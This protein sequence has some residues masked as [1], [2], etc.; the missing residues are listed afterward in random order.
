[1]K[2][3]TNIEVSTMLTPTLT[4]D[5]ID[6]INRKIS[7]LSDVIS[8]IKIKNP[9][10]F[11]NDLNWLI[12]KLDS[13]KDNPAYERNLGFEEISTYI[14]THFDHNVELQDTLKEAVHN[15]KQDIYLS[16]P[17]E[18][19]SLFVDNYDIFKETKEKAKQT[20]DTAS[21]IKKDPH[22]AVTEILKD[23]QSQAKLYEGAQPEGQESRAARDTFLAY[24]EKRMNSIPQQNKRPKKTTSIEDLLDAEGLALY[25]NAIAEE[26]KSRAFR[27]AVFLKSTQHYDGPKW[28]KKL[29]LWVGGPSAS[30]KTYA[31]SEAVKAMATKM[32]HATNEE[33]E[34]I[35]TGNDV[36]SVDGGIE[37]EVSQMR[38]LVLQVALSKGYKGISDL[39]AN[40]KFDTKERV[41]AAALAQEDLS[42]VIPETFAESAISLKRFDKEGAYKKNEMREYHEMPNVVQ[43][44]SEVKAAPGKEKSFQVAVSH[45]GSSRAWF[46]EQ[47][48]FEE[49]DIKINNREIGCE[50]KVYDWK[51]FY[52]GKYAS[53]EACNNLKE[54]NPEGT[55]IQITNDLIFVKSNP[56]GTWQ[57][58]DYNDT[59]DLKLSSRDFERWQLEKQQSPATKGLVEWYAD[60]KKNGQLA[61][62]LI[63][64]MPN[65][66][67]KVRK[68]DGPI[69]FLT[70]RDFE[71]WLNE[72]KNNPKSTPDL[73]DWCMR[74]HHQ[75]N[76][77]TP[78]HLLTHYMKHIPRTVSAPSR[79]ENPTN[80]DLTDHMPERSPSYNTLDPNQMANKTSDRKSMLFSAQ[81]SPS[82]EPKSNKETQQPSAP[83]LPPRSSKKPSL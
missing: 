36:V 13:L 82:T 21:V 72:S 42:L 40:T 3:H 81:E 6:T 71:K 77:I 20:G 19:W 28:D 16:A 30:G 29:I 64:M 27:D 58:C 38:Q 32:P 51:G 78:L 26:G 39:H 61:P 56:N 46:D 69:I 50:S 49:V 67:I 47:K 22:E 63:L 9:G 24:L 37:R 12:N 33:N 41:K 65:D 8:H 79:L 74:Q 73:L 14:S 75:E 7:N 70:K 2:S 48:V 44:F 31:A 34:K 53:E 55:Y 18:E 66:M 54:M 57:E 15:V 80:Q 17:A 1:M 5:Q 59:P 45:M 62:P 83:T 43:A 23:S 52:P 68:D 35:N 10:A 11:E 76:L 4:Q 60:Q 25:K